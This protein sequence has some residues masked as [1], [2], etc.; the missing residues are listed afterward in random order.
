MVALHPV[1]LEQG[2]L[3]AAIRAIADLY[4]R[5]GGF[6]V[7]LNV[8]PGA[9]G[10]RDQLIV[11]LAQE[12]LSN[13]ARHAQASHV[14]IALR[15]VDMG[16]LFEVADDGRGMTAAR[17]RQALDR[18]HVGLAS[19]TMRVESLG[20]NFQRVS[21]PGGG[22]R[23]RSVIPVGPPGAEAAAGGYVG[24]PAERRAHTAV[25]IGASASIP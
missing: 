6:D 9:S 15:R 2:G 4:A 16:V 25:G 5:R 10:L 23:V 1:T 24:G 8:E 13:I 21:S 7:A 3:T 14:T 12:L 22:T 11:S 19:V 17:P 20:G 18:G